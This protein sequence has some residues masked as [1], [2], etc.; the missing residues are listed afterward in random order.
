MDV[1]RTIKPGDPG[2]RRFVRQ[3]GEE[4]VA[5]RYRRATDGSRLFTTIELVVDSRESKPGVNQHAV[6]RH[7]AKKWVAVRIE[8]GETELRATVKRNKAR[9]SRSHQVWLMR[10]EQAVAMGLSNRIIPGLA[11][12]CDDVGLDLE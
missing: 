2:S 3:Y 8:Y 1:I 7:Q 11:G 9:W 10:H 12:Q 6:L 4:L 5:V